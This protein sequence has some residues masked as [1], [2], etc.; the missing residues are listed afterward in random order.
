MKFSRIELAPPL[1]GVERLQAFFQGYSFTPHRHD[2]Y[3]V[4]MTTTGA[5]TFDYRGA[6]R[7]SLPGQ[8]FVL[9]PDERHD[10][11]AGDEHGFGYRIAYVDPALIIAAAE[12]KTLP[13]LREPVSADAGLRGAIVG[14]VGLDDEPIDELSNTCNLVSLA[15]S[16]ARVARYAPS[17]ASRVDSTAMRQ[18][19]ELLLARPEERTSVDE[20]ESASGLTRWQLARQF[21]KV[22]GVSLYRFQLLR[23][24]DRARELLGL[25]RS[26]ADIAQSCGFADQAHLT[27]K[28]RDAYGLSPGRWRALSVG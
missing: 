6:T 1:P 28:F 17:L 24:L 26:L 10:G 20:L 22:Y 14:L 9:H 23:R 2:S 4:G 21:R 11:R 27:R 25:G 3:A 7:R 19:R 15:D 16:L 13:F 18:V 8:V 12:M 5:Q